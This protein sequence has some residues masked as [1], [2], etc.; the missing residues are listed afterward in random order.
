MRRYGPEVWD[1]LKDDSRLLASGIV[2]PLHLEKMLQDYFHRGRGDA[3]RPWFILSM[4][5]WLRR[6]ES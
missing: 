6:L 2:S 4:E 1:R 5:T 3:L